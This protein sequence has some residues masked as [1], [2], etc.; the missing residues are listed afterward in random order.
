MTEVHANPLLH[1]VRH[2]LGAVSATRLSDGQ[3][4]ERFLAHRD[5]TAVEVLVRRYGPLV[6]GVCRRVLHNVHTAEDAFQATF[7][8]LIRKASSLDRGR[9]LGSWLYTVAFRLALRARANEL[10]RRRCEEV[11]ARGRPAPEGPL[12]S[13]SDLEVALEE[14]LNKL[15]E[16]Y[17]APLVLC[18]LQG[19]TNDQAAEI[20]GCPRGSMAARL[21][22]ARARLRENL[23]RRGF[24]VPAAAVA[25][26]LAAAGAEASV[27]LPLLANT[28]RAVLWF[29]EGTAGATALVSA[30]VVALARAACR[31]MVLNQLKFAGA[32]LLAVALFGSGA[33][34]LLNAA[35]QAD[36][37]GQAAPPVPSGTQPS[38]VIPGGADGRVTNAAVPY[39]EAFLALRRQPREYARLDVDCLTMPLDARARDQVTRGAYALRQMRRGAALPRCDWTAPAERGV[40]L[41]FNPGEGARALSGLACLRARLSFAEGRPAEALEDI[42][43]ALT[44]AR[45][46]AREG[47]L[48][49]LWDGYEIERQMGET[50]ALYLPGLDNRSL[51]DV[52]ARLEALPPGGSAAT[53]TGHMLEAMLNWV[54]GETREAKDREIL[55]AFLTQLVPCT[56]GPPE[57]NRPQGEAL[58][59][60]CGG[61]AEGVLRFAEQ[62]RPAAASLAKK[63]ELPPDQVEAACERAEKQLASNP[64][65]G[66]F[67]PILHKVR[68]RQAQAQIRRA[69]LLAAVAVRLGG[70][71][72]LPQHLDPVAGGPFVLV[73]VEG[74]FELQSKALPNENGRS[75]WQPEPPPAVVLRVGRPS[76][77]AGR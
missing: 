2:L 47:T 63:L 77:E 22:Q 59:T 51:K 23:A 67:A 30:G 72:A 52:K 44:L 61:T 54:I 60:A 69:L 56:G 35:P 21:D 17:R 1:E 46:L 7:L 32:L 5:D 75:G 8:V 12:P 6:F 29:A 27:P 43:A 15:P 58:L 71:E 24:V 41:S 20:L 37:G 65:F 19:K 3:L 62:M 68:V 11:A 55:L 70:Q 42:L 14:E 10:R 45:Q 26:A 74:G 34:L 9:P 39:G 64:M 31:A 66:V 38:A 73:P 13:P 49:S 25:A 28:V 33:T 76:A 48:H 50:L 16:R 18:H 36:V 53:A 40:A 57:G 4:L